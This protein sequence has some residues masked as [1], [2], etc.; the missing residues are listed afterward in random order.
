MAGSLSSV[1]SRVRPSGVVT[2][3]VV[4]PVKGRITLMQV[5]GLGVLLSMCFVVVYMYQVIDDMH[6]EQQAMR[7]QIA[8]L[9]GSAGPL[10]GRPSAAHRAARTEDGHPAAAAAARQTQEHGGISMDLAG[11]GVPAASEPDVKDPRKLSFMATVGTGTTDGCFTV[12]TTGTLDVSATSG[13]TA[14]G[15]PGAR[16]ACPDCF[17]M[18]ASVTGDITLT[19][20]SCSSAHWN[21]NSARSGVWAYTFINADDAQ[22][23]TVT[24]D[25]SSPLSYNIPP[26]SYVQAYCSS[27]A[28]G[29][30]Q[31][32]LFYPS[33]QLPTLTIDNG[34]TLSA[35]N[36]LQSGT[37]T[38]TTASGANTLNGDV[39][40][41]GTKTFT[42]GSGDIAL[43]GAT[44]VATD[45][46][47]TV[48]A[49]ASTAAI[50]MYG[51][52]AVGT[53]ANLRTLT[54]NG[55]FAQ[56]GA[57]TVTTG[58]GA[59][60]L[61]GHTTIAAGKNLAMASGAGTFTTGTGAVT[62]NGAT[63][64]SG[65]NTFTTGTGAIALQ[66][67][68]TI[69]DGKA[70]NVGSTSASGGTATFNGPVVVGDS[71]SGA[72]TSFTMYGN[73][74]QNDGGVGAGTTFSTGTG[75]ISAN[76]DVLVASGKDLTM[77]HTGGGTFT[78]GMGNVNF[79][80]SVI[81][82]GANTFTSGTGVN[83][84]NGLTK[85]VNGANFHVGDAS[86]QGSSSLMGPVT[87]GDST[88]GLSS[89][90][91]VYGDVTF[92]DDTTP[93]AKSF[94]SD[95][96]GSFTINTDVAIGQHK[97]LLMDTGGTGAF[98]TGTGTVTLSGNT[99]V[100]DGAS[101][102][103]GSHG[104]DPVGGPHAVQCSQQAAYDANLY[105]CYAR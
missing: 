25:S 99:I 9:S 91:L 62:L 96:S 94:T 69:S 17:V 53:A 80:G 64:I 3:H 38:F 49:D 34:F 104:G 40:I 52:V 1:T 88:A 33:M 2:P 75:T 54:L 102:T 74:A 43:N 67:D 59:I 19:I 41:S 44:T 26:G 5:L 10:R 46:D 15:V 39:T 82:N 78:S 22:T 14:C 57:T 66:G 90:L 24:D 71:S 60:A 73:F 98:S 50:T 68:T 92:R 86:S 45:K 12:D 93:T 20:S 56:S 13:A 11:K 100:A 23:L 77:V 51:T 84:F 35:G 30:L 89:S 8:Q 27:S 83:T 70:L 48:G 79:Y 6:R 37:G 76:G 7:N 65:T 18:P 31:N 101:F 28:T 4:S 55:N 103:M 97:D 87:V 47:F 85:V 16:H 58:T 42:T 29:T 95:L 32:K 105:Y 63:T 21:R 72:T 61:N 81:I 36:F